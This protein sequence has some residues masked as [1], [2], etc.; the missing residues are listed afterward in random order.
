MSIRRFAYL[1]SAASAESASAVAAARTQHVRRR[2]RP[3]KIRRTQADSAPAP[4][5]D[6]ASADAPVGMDDP[7]RTPPSVL[8]LMRTAQRLVRDRVPV[9]SE[10]WARFSFNAQKCADLFPRPSAERLIRLCTHANVLDASFFDVLARRLVDLDS[11]GE[12]DSSP[13]TKRD[14]LVSASR[15][16]RDF[17]LLNHSSGPLLALWEGALARYIAAES[18]EGGSRSGNGGKMT[19]SDLLSVLSAAVVLDERRVDVVGL[20]GQ[21]VG[22][23][24][25][26]APQAMAMLLQAS[27]ASSG[28]QAPRLSR[29]CPQLAIV[30]PVSCITEKRLAVTQPTSPPPSDPNTEPAP[31]PAA[32]SD[33]QSVQLAQVFTHFRTWLAQAADV[34]STGDLSLKKDA[35]RAVGLSIAGMEAI[36]HHLADPL[37]TA[38]EPFSHELSRP[39]THLQS[40]FWPLLIKQSLDDESLAL[41][42]HLAQAYLTEGVCVAL[43]WQKWRE[44]VRKVLEDRGEEREGLPEAKEEIAAL[45]GRLVGRYM[46]LKAIEGLVKDA[47]DPQSVNVRHIALPPDGGDRPTRPDIARAAQLESELPWLA[48]QLEALQS[49]AQ[50]SEP[51]PADE[52]TERGRKRFL[53]QVNRGFT[54][55]GTVEGSRDE[56]AKYM[57]KADGEVLGEVVAVERE[58]R[59]ARIRVEHNNGSSKEYWLDVAH[60]SRDEEAKV[61]GMLIEKQE[62]QDASLPIVVASP[63]HVCLS[64]SYLLEHNYRTPYVGPLDDGCPQTG[65]YVTGLVS[66]ISA[67]RTRAHVEMNGLTGVGWC[68]VP[69]GSGSAKRDEVQAALESLCKSK[70]KATFRVLSIA[71]SSLKL[72]LTTPPDQLDRTQLQYRLLL[73]MDT[74]GDTADDAEGEGRE[75]LGEVVAVDRKASRAKI[76][77]R[78]GGGRSKDYSLDFFGSHRY[79]VRRLLL[80]KCRAKDASLPVVITSR[81]RVTISRS[82]LAALVQGGDR[83]G[84]AAEDE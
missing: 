41:L 82:Y 33:R 71:P 57:R 25:D 55:A 70:E 18:G 52:I 37:F 35:V 1:L 26:A 28:N 5:A 59:R 76:R 31:P 34:M 30:W 8:S 83:Q 24:A 81:K 80:Q 66:S 17:A 23:L 14:A 12:A 21:A 4:A 62:S 58:M 51:N 47:C 39:L 22:L 79:A 15:V 40:T 69:R 13:P 75:M 72:W 6:E 42:Q 68:I 38:L 3:R 27:S 65:D 50:S 63:R 64:P 2:R 48:A 46:G 53:Q 9:D 56:K 43:V 10:D 19:F 32:L 84:T 11:E 44:A 16:L 54:Q 60:F 29:L 7:L 45:K 78:L 20:Q 77:V 49:Y 74:S 61:T 36:Q 67:D 73:A